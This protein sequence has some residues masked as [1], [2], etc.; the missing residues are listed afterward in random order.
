MNKKII[1]SALVMSLAAIFSFGVFAV[2]SYAEEGDDASESAPATSI[3]IMPVSRTLQIESSTDYDGTLTVTNDGDADI[4][5]KAYAAPYSYVRSE[6]D[7]YQLGFS[8]ETNF[9]QISRWI[10]IKDADGNYTKEPTFTVKAHESL[11]IEYKITTPKNIPAG[12]QYA[13]IFV[14]T[15]SNTANS[16]GIRT[17]ASAGMVVYGRS[18]EGE[19]VTSSEISDLQILQ[20]TE[21]D[22]TTREGSPEDGA[23]N[24]NFRATAKV[25]NTG[26][27][28]F[29]A[30]GI[31]KVEPII[32]F[33]SYET[34]VNNSSLSVIP[35]SERIISDEWT[36]TPDFG[37]YKVTWT[38]EAGDNTE[39]T[40]RVICLISPLAIIIF[41]IVLTFII[42][43]VI[44][45]VRKRKDRR[46]R[47]AI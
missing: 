17:E 40:E 25:K 41:I 16:S 38:V 22:S 12:G 8:N 34:E 31:L 43:M 46:S 29:F 20:G 6:D 2:N 30:H 13:V 28:D 15:M 35:E 26:N 32:G 10:S 45:L 27:V 33:A 18:T 44:I 1:A 11:E 5:V 21:G 23:K 4:K 39:S 42:V 9:T 24:N 14:Q 37:I 19:A 7:V 36:E 47:L 3:S